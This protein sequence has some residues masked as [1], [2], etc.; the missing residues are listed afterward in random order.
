MAKSVSARVLK[1]FAACAA[2][3]VVAA[4]ATNA[5]PAAVVTALAA[6]EAADLDVALVD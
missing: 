5:A 1:G 6:A 3:A 4:L 2:E